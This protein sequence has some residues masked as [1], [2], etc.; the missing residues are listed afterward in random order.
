MKRLFVFSM[1]LTWALV[2]LSG[3]S[4]AGS[5]KAYE[6]YFLYLGEH[7]ANANPGWHEDVQ[8]VTHDDSYWFITQAHEEDTS[9]QALWKIPVSHDLGSVSPSD[10]GVTRILV[11]DVSEL[12]AEGYWH[13][14][15]LSY[16][17][18]DGQG[19][20]IIPVEFGC[21]AISIF[22]ADNLVF[23]DYF[24]ICDWQAN[25]SWCAVDPT[26]GYLYSSNYENVSIIK[27]YDPHWTN[28][29]NS[30]SLELTRLAD[31]SLLDENGSGLTLQHVQ[32]GV[33]S[34]SGQLLYIVADGIH[35]FDMQSWRRV[36]QS[37]NGYG[38]FNYEFHPGYL[39]EPEGITIW[40]LDGGNAPGINGQLH[41]LM[42]DNDIPLED[43]DDV[44]FKHYTNLL[45][46]DGDYT[47]ADQ[48]GRPWDP[49]KTVAGANNYAWNG[50]ALAIK[51]GSYPETLTFSKRIQLLAKEGT[52]TI[53]TTG[54]ISLTSSARINIY[55]GGAIKLH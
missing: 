38:H 46:V 7:P 8:G 20:L 3:V 2:G 54:R 33:I 45:W 35:V 23:V 21:H 15:D 43:D 26:T 27:E 14:G 12:A 9:E 18:F 36:Q 28:V 53:G 13:L 39:E 32:G 51:A 31:I 24:K 10:P 52:S 47:G 50:A 6:S 1:I 42:L 22:R 29:K 5:L 4:T 44:Y 40:D 25:A 34:T 19:Y 55:S 49:F 11:G 41:V 16:Y 30:G 37:T 48:N 17:K